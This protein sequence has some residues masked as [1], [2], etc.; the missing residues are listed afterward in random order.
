MKQAAGVWQRRASQADSVQLCHRGRSSLRVK[1][2]SG[3]QRRG[4][5]PDPSNHGVMISL[6][7]PYRVHFGQGLAIVG[8]NTELG[9]W[10]TAR[11]V[12][13]AWSSG[14]MWEAELSLSGAGELEYKYLVLNA[15]GS[16]SLWKPGQNY[17]LAVP[18][19]HGTIVA[20]LETWDDGPRKVDVQ[21]TEEQPSQASTR[22]VK[23]TIQQ[24]SDAA[25]EELQDT[26][27][28]HVDAMQRAA[29]PS[30]LDMIIGDRLLAAASNKALTLQK[31]I[32][33][34]DKQRQ[35]TQQ[36]PDS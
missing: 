28:S 29:A 35:L 11:A 24:E 3:E 1:C 7:L 30:A 2:W 12:R 26:L 16:V 25:L 5:G 8:A 9:A 33:A 6:K 19:T 14:D 20:V 17:K 34:A 32:R 4:S 21:S 27:T 10:D 15:D 31:A 22:P 23:S 18:A 36:R 13:M